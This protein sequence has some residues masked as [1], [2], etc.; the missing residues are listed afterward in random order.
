MEIAVE[1]H[2]QV[3]RSPHGVELA[4][5]EINAD[6][7]NNMHKRALNNKLN[8]HYTADWPTLPQYSAIIRANN[9]DFAMAEY[10]ACRANAVVVKLPEVEETGEAVAE[11]FMDITRELGEACAKYQEAFRDKRITP[12]EFKE[13]KQEFNDVVAAVM[14]AKAL[15][16]KGVR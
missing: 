5:A 1:L 14:R 10:H 2:R 4:L 6:R 7:A 13:I 8:P 12:R 11:A 16:K 15:I 3:S 9:L